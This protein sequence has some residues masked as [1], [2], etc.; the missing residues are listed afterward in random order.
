MKDSV[1]SLPSV[2]Q[3]LNLTSTK[4]LL[5]RYRRDYVTEAVRLALQQMREQL[6][7]GEAGGWTAASRGALAAHIEVMVG[8]GLEGADRASLHRVVNATGV[9]LHTGLGRA[10]LA[11]AAANAVRSV[12]ESYCNLELDLRTGARGSRLTHIEQLIR[13]LS[14]GE[15]AAVVNNN[16]GA[17]LLML[18]ALARGRE[19]VISR[20]ELVEIGG[21]FR[22][23]DIIEA[24][25]AAIREVGTTN[26][27]H[28]VDYE[29]ALNAD[30]ALI[31]AVHPSNYRVEGFTSGVD[32]GQLAELGH[33]AGLPVAYDLGGGALVDLAEWGL[34]PEPVVSACLATG[35]DVVS[36]SGDKVLGGPQAGIIAGSVRYV[37]P[38][39]KHPMMRALRCDKLTLAALEATLKLYRR[40]A[41]QMAIDHPVLRMLAEPAERARAR[42]Q[43]ALA[44]LS[45]RARAQLCPRVEASTA[46]AGSGALP[47]VELPSWA[48]S[49]TPGFCGIEALASRLRGRAVPVVGRI[50]K[51][52][53]FLDMRTV[54][55][56]DLEAVASALEGVVPVEEP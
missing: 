4:E 3:I 51:E 14:G 21:S 6:L 39:R 13:E 17:V 45:A 46:Q 5:R 28:L 15:A 27:T 34:P 9:I 49:L 53:L 24:S 1:K 8:T 31:L 37:E 2:D 56:D 22:I 50:Q 44:M 29:R 19:V 43:G 12:A 18:S 41:A 20:G 26:R 16:A 35:V 54:G 7:N 33:R 10:P 40:P 55:D 42:A 47:L 38:M 52:K 11:A 32:L 36:F 25:G 23:P 30:T 48:L